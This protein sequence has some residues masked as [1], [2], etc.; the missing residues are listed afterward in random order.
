MDSQCGSQGHGP[1]S[2]WLGMYDVYIFIFYCMVVLSC[3]LEMYVRNMLEI[4]KMVQDGCVK[5]TRGVMI[6]PEGKR[7]GGY[8]ENKYYDANC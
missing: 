5:R 3:R 6:P 1:T 4:N 8:G 7:K 2:E